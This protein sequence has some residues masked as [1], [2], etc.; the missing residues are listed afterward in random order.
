MC[1]RHKLILLA[2][3]APHEDPWDNAPSVQYR[4]REAP[5]LDLVEAMEL[6]ERDWRATLHCLM[7]TRPLRV[8]EL[9]PRQRH[10]SPEYL[11]GVHDTQKPTWQQPGTGNPRITRI[12]RRSGRLK[13][14]CPTPR[15]PAA[16]GASCSSR[17]P[18]ALDEPSGRDAGIRTQSRITPSS[19]VA[20]CPSSS[21]PGPP[22]SSRTWRS[23]S[24]HASSDRH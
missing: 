15:H 8:L 22:V 19:A 9:P 13:A 10:A 6:K 2:R 3:N 5:V 1:V 4:C 20:S 16:A 17:V 12:K 24:H 21:R 11:R 18:Q 7:R 23:P 14:C